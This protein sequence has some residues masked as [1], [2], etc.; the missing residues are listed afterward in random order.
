MISDEKFEITFLGCLLNY[1]LLFITT[2]TQEKEK[3]SQES[4]SGFGVGR[5]VC[6]C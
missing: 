2:V 6:L 4:I 5:Q 1:F 3:N